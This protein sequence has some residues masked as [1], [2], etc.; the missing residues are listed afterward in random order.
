MGYIVKA[1]GR[2]R[3][4]PMEILAKEKVI[5]QMSLTDKLRDKAIDLFILGRQK[6]FDVVA[7]LAELKQ[8]CRS[9]DNLLHKFIEIQIDFAMADG[10]LS[11]PNKAAL[12]FI[13]HQLGI[14]SLDFDGFEKE[15]RT[16]H[17]YQK[18]Q[19]E[20]HLGHSSPLENAYNLLGV[21]ATHSN[22]EI[23]KIYRR[24]MNQNHPDKL[25]AKGFPPQMIEL[26]TQKTQQI[27]HAYETIK[28]RR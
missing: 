15:H 8:V 22:L 7:N 16:F 20:Y 28:K 5:Y 10:D 21:S 27:Q 9:D 13:C 2:F 18:Q 26:A 3:S 14:N 23:K 17:A 24:L 11:Q 12:Q 1:D 25:I 6:Y 4:S 19:E